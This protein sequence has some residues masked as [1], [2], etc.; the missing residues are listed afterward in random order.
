MSHSLSDH[1]TASQSFA[2]PLDIGGLRLRNRFVSAPMER[3]YC[4]FDGTMSDRYIAYLERRAAGARGP[5][6]HRGRVRPRRRQGPDPADGRRRGRAHPRHRP[7]GRGVHAHG[8]LL[9]V[10]LNHGGRTAQ[11]AVSG[12]VPVAPS[13]I[14]CHVVGGEMP[15]Q[16]GSDDIEHIIECYG[17]AA[18]RCQQAG[19]DV[20]S[21]HGGHGYLIHQFLSPRTTSAT[22]SGRIRRSSS[23]G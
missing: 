13:P 6:V 22:T 1:A 14:P 17:E 19:V 20:I 11:G 18:A 2:Q 4:D 10:E 15:E 23:T 12:L 8:A 21:L 3:N 5:G 9:G 7:A 16:L